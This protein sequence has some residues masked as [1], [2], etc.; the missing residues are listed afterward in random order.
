[1]TSLLFRR[2]TRA[3]ALILFLTSACA[4]PMNK[5]TGGALA[6]SALGAGLGAIVGSQS[7]HAGPGIAIGA[8]A[9][10]L[11]G[12]VLGNSMDNTDRETADLRN[13][14]GDQ[15]RQIEENRRLID[16]LRRRGADVHSTRRGVVINLPD[17]LF[18]FDSD[19]L[20]REAHRTVSEIA[21]VLKDV[22]GRT[23]SVEGHT[24][25][26]GTAAY[27][28]K[29]S[30][31]RADSVARELSYNRIP[32]QQLR[33]RGYGEGTPIASNNTEAGRSRNRRVEV[34]IEN[35]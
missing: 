28:K 1:M 15:D 6:G 11:G 26:V 19:R 20:T 3:L 25:S 34:V 16:E 33:V 10:A 12:A 35:N 18:E 29:L 22:R 5:A 8:A 7:G 14:V 4:Q 23:I 27:N 9:G 2:S 13:R 24:D 21:D 30:L 32:D 17:I 31:R